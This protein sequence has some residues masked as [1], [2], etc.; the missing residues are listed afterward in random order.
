MVSP[1][2]ELLQRTNPPQPSLF[3]SGAAREG[4][5]T[6]SS[7]PVL[8]YYKRF[9]F[10]PLLLYLLQIRASTLQFLYARSGVVGVAPPLGPPRHLL[11]AQLLLHRLRLLFFP[12]LLPSCV[13]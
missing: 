10:F 12:L 11:R 13:R 4:G 8:V 2:T 3:P 7:P 6:A 1:H 5:L 9:L